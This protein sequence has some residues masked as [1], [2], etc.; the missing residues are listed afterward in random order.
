MKF[1]QQIEKAGY[2]KSVRTGEEVIIGK[3]RC[4]KE[5]MGCVIL[6]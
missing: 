1:E 2:I 4:S 3:A 6:G 5:M